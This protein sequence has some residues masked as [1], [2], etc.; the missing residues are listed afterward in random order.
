[1]KTGSKIMI[2]LVSF[3]W[4]CTAFFLVLFLCHEMEWAIVTGEWITDSWNAIFQSEHSLEGF[5]NRLG[6]LLFWFGIGYAIFTMVFVVCCVKIN[7][8]DEDDED[9][10]EE[11]ETTM[12]KVEKKEKAEKKSKRKFSLKKSAETMK[13]AAE[14]TEKI[15][16][17][18]SKAIDS[19][20]SNLRK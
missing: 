12:K 1:M 3:G 14:T 19:F 20:L 17:S 10:E 2:T 4:L 9:E 16:D 7:S 15:A 8:P 6:D 13:E 5:F 11:E 18:S